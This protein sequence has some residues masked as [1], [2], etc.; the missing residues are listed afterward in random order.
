VFSCCHYVG[1]KDIRFVNVGSQERLLALPLWSDLANVV[2]RAASGHAV[3]VLLA[4]FILQYGLDCDFSLLA[5]MELHHFLTR[6]KIS[7]HVV[8]RRILLMRGAQSVSLLS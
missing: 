4:G 3:H 6:F 8:V 7:Q 5:D 2:E 1:L